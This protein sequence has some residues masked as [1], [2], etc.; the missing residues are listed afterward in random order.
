MRTQVRRGRTPTF[1]TGAAVALVVVATMA[2]PARSMGQELQVDRRAG[3][4]VRFI[5]RASIEEFEGVTDRIDGYVLLD[6]P[7]LAQAEGGDA[8]EVYLE[9]DLASLDTGIGLRN[10]HMRENYL[11]VEEFPFATFRGRILGRETVP[12]GGFRVTA[13]GLFAVHGVSRSRQLTCRV[14]EEGAGYR[15]QCGF[16]VLLSDH[17]IEI[18]KVMFLKLANDIRLELE[19]TMIPAGAPNGDTP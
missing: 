9:V 1:A 16:E 4:V 15:A 13:Q 19:F 17:D 7:T 8:T 11:E 5:S 18:P 12:E 14:Q 10:R 3:N 6:A 2:A